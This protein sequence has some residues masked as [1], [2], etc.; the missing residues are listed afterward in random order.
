MEQRAQ[1]FNIRGRL[2]TGALTYDQA[3]SEAAPVIEAMNIQGK[4]IAKKHGKRFTAF[5]FSQ[6]MR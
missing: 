6:F 4:A 5:T 2:L 1:L 3:Q